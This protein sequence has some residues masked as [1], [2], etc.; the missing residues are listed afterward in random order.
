MRREI[1]DQRAGGRGAVVAAVANERVDVRPE[2]PGPDCALV[3]GGVARTR[4][5]NETAAVA[6]IIRRQRSQSDRRQQLRLA[7]SEDLFGARIVGKRE[8]ETDGEELA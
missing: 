8:G 3:V 1:R 4:I 6:R 5:A 2:K 7:N